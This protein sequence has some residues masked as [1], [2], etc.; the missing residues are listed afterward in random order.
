[1]GIWDLCPGFRVPD[2]GKRNSGFEIRVRAYVVGLTGS[3]TRMVETSLGVSG[4]CL[5]VLG[6]EEVARVYVYVCVCVK[7][8]DRKTERERESVCVCERERE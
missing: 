4:V 3:G 5:A 6:D 8:R 2:A 7:E 1:M